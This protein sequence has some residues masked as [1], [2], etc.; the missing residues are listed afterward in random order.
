MKTWLERPRDVG[1]LYNPAFTSRVLYACLKSYSENGEGSMPYSIAF[2]I[3]PVCLTKGTRDG[4]LSNRVLSLQSWLARNPEM[5]IQFAESVSSMR[6][7]TRTSLLW[8]T[9]S[10]LVLLTDGSLKLSDGGPPRRP[11]GMR[12]HDDVD[13]AVK[14]A[15]VL[16]R[17]FAKAGT[18]TEIFARFGITP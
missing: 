6:D 12:D 8:L 16:G 2:L 13:A 17:L 14:A 3:L 10:N 15:T 7:F 9:N 4:L 11:S 5:R 18:A 1:Y